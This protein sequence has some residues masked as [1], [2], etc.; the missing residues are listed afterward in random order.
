MKIG[1]SN[2]DLRSQRV[3][4]LENSSKIST[5]RHTGLT[6]KLYQSFWL[7]GLFQHVK[8]SFL[9]TLG[10]TLMV[11]ISLF[12]HISEHNRVLHRN[13]D[14]YGT[15]IINIWNDL[16]EDVVYAKNLNILKDIIDI[17]FRAYKYIA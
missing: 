6:F 7:H 2:E 12:K 14:C 3:Y 1:S 15:Q 5:M 11:H 16:P 8:T 9:V 13:R 10:I 4:Q 17:H